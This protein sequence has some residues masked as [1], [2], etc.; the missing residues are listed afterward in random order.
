MNN[1]NESQFYEFWKKFASSSIL[2]KLPDNIEE[3]CADL[4]I[5]VDYYIQEFI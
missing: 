4:G 1:L 2:E 3:I 5:T